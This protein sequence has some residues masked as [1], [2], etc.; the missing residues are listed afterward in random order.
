MKL[1]TEKVFFFFCREWVSEL[2]CIDLVIFRQLRVEFEK[3]SGE[4][5]SI[6]HEK[7]K[8]GPWKLFYNS[9]LWWFTYLLWS[10]VFWNNQILKFLSVSYTWICVK[11]GRNCVYDK[12]FNF[13]AVKDI[14]FKKFYKKIIRPIC[15]VLA[16]L[17]WILFL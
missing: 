6:W 11:Y 2:E 12:C 14:L 7:D 1:R 17:L 4:N 16:F 5:R 9:T 3:K 13:E 8:L 10:Y 15:S